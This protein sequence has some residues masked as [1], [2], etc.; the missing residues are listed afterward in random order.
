[1]YVARC[2]HTAGNRRKIVCSNVYLLVQ[3]YIQNSSI[4]TDFVYCQVC[5]VT[6]ALI[7]WHVAFCIHVRTY[8]HAYNWLHAHAS[9]LKTLA[10]SRAFKLHMVTR[11]PTKLPNKVYQQNGHGIF[12]QLLLMLIYNL[13]IEIS[14]YI[15]V[16][17]DS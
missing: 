6:K 12:S 11:T 16:S 14:Y 9:R 1:M 5:Y 17:C 3:Q 13:I 10:N 8:V 15:D 2:V 7:R 4:L